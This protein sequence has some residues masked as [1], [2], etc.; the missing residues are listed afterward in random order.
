M[1]AMRNVEVM[2]DKFQV[3]EIYAIYMLPN[4]II[5]NLKFVLS[6]LYESEYLE[7]R[8]VQNILLLFLFGN[9]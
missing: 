7:E 2:S 3:I 4:L 6:S 5:T 8:S 1:T 9:I